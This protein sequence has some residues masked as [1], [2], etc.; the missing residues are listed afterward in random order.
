MKRALKVFAKK[1]SQLNSYEK[2]PFCLVFSFVWNP[3]GLC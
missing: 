3:E 1:A 2:N